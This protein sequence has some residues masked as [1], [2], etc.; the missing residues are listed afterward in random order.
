[1]RNDLTRLWDTV[2]VCVTGIGPLAGERRRRRSGRRGRRRW[3][4]RSRQRR[5]R[6]TFISVESERMCGWLREGNRRW[7]TVWAFGLQGRADTRTAR[8]RQRADTLSLTHP[9]AKIAYGNSLSR[10]GHSHHPTPVTPS[11]YP[12]KIFPLHSLPALH[13]IQMTIV[14]Y[15]LSHFS[16]QIYPQNRPKRPSA[17]L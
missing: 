4:R 17:R 11:A 16:S 5:G 14:F 2:L 6:H 10:H 12:K 15:H 7:D 9:S 3:R 13:S 1:M 8:R